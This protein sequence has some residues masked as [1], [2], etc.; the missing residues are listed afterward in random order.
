MSRDGSRNGGLRWALL[1]LSIIGRLLASPPKRGELQKA[2]RD[3][4]SQPYRHP[5]KS[6]EW[7]TFGPSTIERWFYR[8]RGE[9]DPVAALGRKIRSDAGV[10]KVMDQELLRELQQQYRVHLGWTYQL[11]H[12]NLVALV[13]E[14]SGLGPMP[15]YAT[16]RRR[17]QERGWYRRPSQRRNRTDGQKKAQE[18]LEKREVRSYEATHVHA[19][20]HYDFHE[21][22]RRVIDER[23]QCHVPVLFAVMDDRSRVCCHGQWYLAETAENLVHGLGQ[24]FQKRGLPRSAMSDNGSAMLAGETTSGLERLG[25]LLQTTLAYSPYQNGKQE[26]F[27]GN[28]E[29][30]LLPM[31]EKVEPLTL[32]FLNQA[33]QAW[34]ELDYNKSRHSELGMSPLER[35][36]KEPDVSRPA[37]GS[38][39]LRFAFTVRRTRTQRRSDGTVSMD[40]VRFE[41]PSRF[42]NLRKLTVRYRRWDLS[43]AY[44]VDGRSDEMIARI[45]PVDKARNADG[46]RRTVEPACNAAEPGSRDAEADPIPPLMRKLLADYAA[47]GLPPAYLPKDEN[48]EED[49]E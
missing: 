7:I 36:L 44:I 26:T 23:G 34:V 40:G 49:D 27:W 19:L 24:G 38:D 21:G 47:T 18:R 8:A 11:H 9:P 39:E 6:Q 2:L 25:V 17:M 20:W 35:M 3:L 45:Y 13:E 41:I 22:S 10:T 28:V 29:G 30:R 5:T 15:S 33:T 48:K 32:P 4:A 31:L 16:V 1:R 12:D 14:R 37:P 46:L 42:R 43:F